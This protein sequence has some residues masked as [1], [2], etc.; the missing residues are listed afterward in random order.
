MRRD[1]WIFQKPAQRVQ[2]NWFE[3]VVEYQPDSVRFAAET[4]LD[5]AKFVLRP[6]DEAV[7]ISGPAL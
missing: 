3:D 7:T 2:H 4:S 6:R 1:G 5:R